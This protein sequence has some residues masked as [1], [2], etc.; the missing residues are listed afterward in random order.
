[1]N[2]L[3]SAPVLTASCRSHGCCD[4][5]QAGIQSPQQLHY[6]LITPLIFFMLQKPDE[7]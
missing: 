5:C 3:S 2:F 6:Q 1:M 7:I 4:C